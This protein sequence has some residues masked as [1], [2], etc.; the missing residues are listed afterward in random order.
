M[1]QRVPSGRVAAALA[2]QCPELID[3]VILQDLSGL[4]QSYIFNLNGTSF[5][6]DER[7]DLKAGDTIL[8]FSSQAGG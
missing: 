2:E 6:S 7:I 3:K 5:V 8:L 1:P 4:E